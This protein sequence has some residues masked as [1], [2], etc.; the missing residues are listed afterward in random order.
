MTRDSATIHPYQAASDAA[1][2]ELGALC[3]VDVAKLPGAL[4][5]L[6]E[7]IEDECGEGWLYDL[8]D[9]IAERRTAGRW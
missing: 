9:M 7:A 8:A 1:A 4:A 6:A 2:F 3:A 5:Y